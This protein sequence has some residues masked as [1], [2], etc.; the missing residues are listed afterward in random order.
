[1]VD[2]SSIME[3]DI[4]KILLNNKAIPELRN[5]TILISGATGFIG[6]Y[7]IHM[8]AMD[9][10]RNKG[11]TKIIAIVR[12]ISRA[13]ALFDRYQ[14]NNIIHFIE[15]DICTPLTCDF[16]V[17]YIIHCASNAAPREYM[18]DP[19]GTM[20]TNFMG[21]ANLLN[22]SIEH[23]KK[24]FL[25]VSTIEV[26]GE[27]KNG[28]EGICE[29]TYGIINSCNP[30]S[31][32]PISKKACETL[33]ISYGRQHN[34]PISIGRL[35]YIYGPGM[36]KEDS[37]VAALFPRE[38]ALKHNIVMKSKGEQKRSYCYIT[39]AVAG[40]L[41]ILSKGENQKAYNIASRDSTITIRQMAERLIDLFPTRGLQIEFDLPDE[42]EKKAFSPMT[43]AVLDPSR[44]ES[45]GWISYTDINSGL[46]NT[47]V[48]YEIRLLSQ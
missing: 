35:A 2:L 22:Y 7:L 25:Y 33:C 5:H 10:I 16:D 39:D 28:C 9:A 24:R 14:Q 42:Q 8:L 4:N 3:K 13:R 44:L 17:D 41:T 36:K 31:C 46:Y 37:K 19:A 38:V 23:L 1:M 48:D 45:L 11:N 29:D 47:V 26:Y 18:E 12:S 32:Y 34:I 30:R 6:S 40:L 21:T 15:Q 43:D 20:N 27:M